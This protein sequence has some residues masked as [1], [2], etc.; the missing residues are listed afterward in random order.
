MSFVGSAGVIGWPVTHSKSPLIHRFW[1]AKLGL[2]GDYGRFPVDPSFLGDAVRALPWMG[3]RGVNV[4]VPHK[5]EVTRH[6]DRVDP[7]A[8]QIGAV[9]T[10]VVEDWHLVGY[11]T[12]A[13]GFIEPLLPFLSE[14][15]PHRFV[16]LIGCGGAAKAI[17]AA[18]DE[19]DFT[20]ITYNRDRQRARDQLG[21][22]VW[23]D[24]LNLDLEFLTPRDAASWKEPLDPE[25]IDLLVN[26]TTLGMAG[27]PPLSV[28]F[29]QFPPGLIVYDIVYAPLETPLLAEARARGL[30]TID[31]LQMLVGQ[32]AAA[33]E[34]FYGHPAPREHD[35]ELRALLVA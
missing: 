21:R 33:F 4:T 10:V 23:D 2:E 18:L 3:L 16:H 31:G 9:N 28:A 30:R 7:T 20:F 6:L 24:D 11:N 32:A 29:H 25:R 1:L 19:H 13:E 34:R 15:R 27:Q 12:D 22:Y 14:E 5:V 8:G 35:A 17:A 26:A